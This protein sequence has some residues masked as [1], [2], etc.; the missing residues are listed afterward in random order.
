MNSPYK[1]IILTNVLSKNH[2][3][4]DKHLR[5][6]DLINISILF[7]TSILYENKQLMDVCTGVEIQQSTAYNSELN[8]CSAVSD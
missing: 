7:F 5:S 1:K 6:F 8:L 2:K 4:F 3:Y